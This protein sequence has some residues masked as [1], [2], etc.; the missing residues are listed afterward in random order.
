MV[1]SFCR[2]IEEVELFLDNLDQEI[3]SNLNLTR[4]TSPGELVHSK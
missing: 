3:Y 1:I 2:N 4:Y